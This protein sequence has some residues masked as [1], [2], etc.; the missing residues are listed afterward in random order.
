MEPPACLWLLLAA[1]APAAH[2]LRIDLQRLRE[3][4][5]APAHT[6]AHSAYSGAS[7]AHGTAHGGHS[8]P[9]SYAHAP[10]PRA[11][12]HKRSD[13]QC[14]GNPCPMG[15]PFPCR[16][17]V[18]LPVRY[19]CDGTPDCSDGF[20]ELPE[21]CNAGIRP[22]MEQLLELLQDERDWIIP[23]L[24]NAADPELVAHSLTVSPDLNDLSRSL[25]LQP[26]HEE[27]LREAFDAAQ[28]G[29][30]RPLLRMGMPERSWHAVQHVL[31]KLL[32]S[33]FHY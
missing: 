30:E 20:D 16:D 8:A 5:H 25:H 19:V 21:N 31:L 27:R 12:A 2:G 6:A 33:G 32:E 22:N 14:H 26:I 13:G 1:L 18:C 29:D 7:S 9:R 24:F 17:G 23:Q 10:P 28:E 11:G 3:L 15:Q 4:A